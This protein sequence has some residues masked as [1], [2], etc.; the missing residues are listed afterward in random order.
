V[1][2]LLAVLA[3]GAPPVRAQAGKTPEQRKASLDAHK[4]EFDYLLGDWE[5][6]AESKQ[7]GK[8]RGLWSAVRLD[9]GQILDECRVLGDQGE[10]YYVTTTLRNYNAGLDRWELIGADAGG[11]LQDFGTAR[12]EGD[13]MRIEQTFGVAAGT[14]SKWRIRYHNIRKDGFSWTADRSTDGGKTW[15]TGHQ[16]IEAR[17][18]GPPRSLPALTTVKKPV[19]PSPAP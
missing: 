5:F 10:T 6:T 16:T 13:E 17:R 11:G 14:S 19:T 12:R 9:E 3:A 7:W 15:V 4:S 2:A 18:I 8:F 1:A